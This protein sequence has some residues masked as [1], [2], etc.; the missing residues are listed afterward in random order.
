MFKKLVDTLSFKWFF[1]LMAL[2]ILALFV[3][4]I[5]HLPISWLLAQPSV[6]NQLPESVKLSPSSGTVWQGRTHVSTPQPIGNVSWD[7]SF[8]TLL[9][10][11]ASVEVQWQKEQSHVSGELNAPLFSESGALNVSHLNGKIDLPLLVQLLNAPGLSDLPIEGEL[12]LKQIDLSMDPQ[13]Q[14]PSVFTGNLILNHLSVLGNAFPKI[15]ITPSLKG[16]QLIFNITGGESGWT[17]SGHL[18]VLKNRQYTVALKVTAQS[19]ASMPDWA[20]LLRQQS[21]TVAVL[22]N[23]GRW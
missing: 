18:E 12:R 13:A 2:F 3:S 5:Y 9:M 1:G 8:W 22:N 6:Q 7:L 21:P 14:W 20:G 16:D 23:R 10:G 4:I 19:K 11:Q 17:L 15:L